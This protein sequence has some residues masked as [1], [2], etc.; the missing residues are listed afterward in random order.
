MEETETELM[1]LQDT[2]N[3]VT[4]EISLRLC[5][6]SLHLN[7]EKETVEDHKRQ[8]DLLMHYSVLNDS[9]TIWFDEGII[10]INGMKPTR[11]GNQV[12]E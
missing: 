3:C 4:S 10:T 8:L 11:I 7:K 9:F 12:Y 1:K 2:M 5:D 6:H